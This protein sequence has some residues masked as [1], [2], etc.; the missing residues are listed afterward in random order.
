MLLK[1]FRFARLYSKCGGRA[2]ATLPP[3][4]MTYT[5]LEYLKTKLEVWLV[6][7]DPFPI[8]PWMRRGETA[9]RCCFLCVVEEG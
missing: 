2:V 1:N 3:T 5:V 9:R 4:P 8:F 7:L 6:L